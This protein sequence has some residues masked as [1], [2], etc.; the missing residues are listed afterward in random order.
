MLSFHFSRSDRS[1]DRKER[2]KVLTDKKF[3]WKT[4]TEKE[5]TLSKQI[6]PTSAGTLCTAPTPSLSNESHPH[7]PLDAASLLGRANEFFFEIKMVAGRDME[8]AAKAMPPVYFWSWV[9]RS[10]QSPYA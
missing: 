9:F 4:S 7:L 10:L 6:R 5:L 1:I 3:D 8:T 2:P